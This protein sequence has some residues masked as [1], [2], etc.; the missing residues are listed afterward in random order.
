MRNNEFNTVEIT[1][2]KQVKG[3]EF[4]KTQKSETLSQKDNKLPEGELNEKYF[5]KTIRKQTETNVQYSAKNVQAHGSTTVTSAN[6]A[7]NI[8]ATTATVATAAS[9][10]A[11]TVVAVGTGISVALHDYDYKFNSFVVT[12]DSLT[13]EFYV[14]DHKNEREDGEPYEEY[15]HP[16]EQ[17]I[18]SEEEE[19]EPFTLRVYNKNYDYS[20]PAYLYSNYGEFTN[21]KPNEQYHIVLS[22]NRFGGETIFDEMFTT[23]EN[24][25]VSEFRGVIWD[26]KCNFLTNEMTIQLD[27]I[28]EKNSFSDFKFNLTSELVTASGPLSI[29]YEINKTTEPQTIKLDSN[30]DFNLSLVYDYSFTFIDGGEEKIIEK[31][32]SFQFKD[33]SGAE[34]KFNKFIFDKTANFKN[35]TFDVQLD[36]VDDFNVYSDFVL[37]F[38]YKFDEPLQGDH[39]EEFGVDVP[40]EKTTAVQTISLDGIEISLSESYGYRL[41]CK[42]NGELETLEEGDVTFTDNSGAIVKF[43]EFIFD[44]TINYDTREITFQLDYIDELDY[45]YGFEF[46]L[47][48]IETQQERSYYLDS[49]TEAQTIEVNEIKEYDDDDNPVYYIDPVKHQVKYS[50]K[51]WKMDQEI[52]VI[53]DKECKFKNSLVSTFTG[54]DTPYDFALES[55]YSSY[56]LPIRFIFDDAAHVYSG[57]EVAFYKNDELYGRL[58]FEGE[59]VHDHWM[60]GVFMGMEGHE[61]DE[62]VNTPI[63]VSVTSYVID[64]ENPGGVET[65]IY[66]ETATFT[67]D[68]KKDFFGIDLLDEPDYPASITYG[69]YEICFMPIYSGQEYL[70]ETALEVECQS[71][72]VYRI[73]FFLQNKNQ[74]VYASLQNCSNFFEENFE[75]D[76]SKPVKLS[77]KYTTYHTEMLPGDSTTEPHEGLVADGD[78]KTLLIS[79]SYQF[80]LNA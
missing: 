34:S 12:S 50:F 51:Y 29:T 71:G 24:D 44:E 45:L 13:C 42:Y 49:T 78:E 3:I 40:L 17:G 18:S 23:K 53:K 37:T 36:Y 30:R 57:F 77:I 15:D 63:K 2:D 4:G 69:Q 5:G 74:L 67:L 61:I 60:N 43:N 35:R 47:M 48:D 9:V 79:E 56:I 22:E 1:N 14:V 41:T 31:G 21:L 65:E 16:R 54:L 55:S 58:A 76:F 52:Y 6:T 8:A 68:Q 27:Y 38:I 32:S 80:M 72:N 59:T 66:S 46:I 10:V 73:P 26:K 19:K 70:F 25:P 33:N 20:I 11:V 39:P 75:N 62:V 64:D 7:S 28:D